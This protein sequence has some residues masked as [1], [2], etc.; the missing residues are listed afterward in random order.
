MF[1]E[2]CMMLTSGCFHH[3]PVIITYMQHLSKWS[4]CYH[5]VTGHLHKTDKMVGSFPRSLLHLSSCVLV[6]SHQMPLYFLQFS[7]VGYTDTLNCKEF[8]NCTLPCICNTDI[9][10]QA[11]ATEAFLRPPSKSSRFL[12]AQ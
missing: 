2:Y 4:V 9:P 10:G 7:K 1:K 8:C 12:S 5:V 6:Q 3:T 11:T